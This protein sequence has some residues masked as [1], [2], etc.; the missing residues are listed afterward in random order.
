VKNAPQESPRNRPDN[1]IS[2]TNQSKKLNLAKKVRKSVDS[3]GEWS[4]NGQDLDSSVMSNRINNILDKYKKKAD[5]KRRNS[6]LDFL[7]HLTKDSKIG[8][9]KAKFEDQRKKF[10]FNKASAASKIINKYKTRNPSPQET[11]KGKSSSF[12]FD[13]DSSYQFKTYDANKYRRK[14]QLQK[15]EH[16]ENTENILNLSYYQLQNRKIS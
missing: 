7:K 9:N 12:Y 16:S 1:Q 3:E 6:K 15:Q 2:F 8:R 4:Q 13:L 5:V 14:Q 11:S 10:S